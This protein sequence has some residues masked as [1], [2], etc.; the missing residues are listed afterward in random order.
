MQ[1][2]KQPRVWRGARVVSPSSRKEQNENTTALKFCSARRL[3][4]ATNFTLCGVPLPGD[5]ESQ[6]RVQRENSAFAKRKREKIHHG[7]SGIILSL[8]FD[9]S[10]SPHVT[11]LSQLLKGQFTSDESP[12]DDSYVK[13]IAGSTALEPIS[14]PEPPKGPYAPQSIPALPRHS[15]HRTNQV[16]M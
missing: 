6:R 5:T 11:A 12:R 15:P 9:N 14:S 13:S 3:Q 2:G 1:G 16:L 4:R 10:R 8:S 7:S